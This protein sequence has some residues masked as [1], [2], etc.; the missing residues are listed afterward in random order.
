MQ[1]AHGELGQGRGQRG[2]GFLRRLNGYLI[3][4][5]DQRTDP[6]GLTSLQAGAADS[7]YN[8]VAARFGEHHR[9]HRRSARRKFID[10]G[11]VEIGI[12]GHC[13]RA[14]DGGGRHDQL[15]GLTS[16]RGTLLAQTQ[17]LMHAESMLLVDD[18]Q[19]QGAKLHAF[20]E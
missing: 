3:R 16:I 14:R 4:F 1:E 7:L 19:R 10:H 5:V 13:Q 15:M 6:I 11:N 17:A 18:D 12:G 20:L 9:L 2:R 8:F